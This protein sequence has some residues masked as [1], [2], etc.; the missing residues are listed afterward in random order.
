M[1]DTL[2]R[3]TGVQVL[4]IIRTVVTVILVIVLFSISYFVLKIILKSRNVYFS[5]LR[6]IGANK[7]VCK[8]LLIIEL[9]NAAFIAYSL[10]MIFLVLCFKNIIK[11]SAI[12]TLMEFLCLRDYILLGIILLFISF[13]VA[14]KFAKK[15]FKDSAIKTIHEEV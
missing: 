7:K 6:M 9:L 2:M 10:M 14:I 3:G 11:L 1:K 5:T 15:L 8:R 12:N 4:R 13:M